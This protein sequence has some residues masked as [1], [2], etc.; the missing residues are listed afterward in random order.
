MSTRW[1]EAATVYVNGNPA[2][3]ARMYAQIGSQPDEAYARL[4][5][6]EELLAADRRGEAE[7]ELNQALDFYRRVGAVRMVREAEALL[8]PT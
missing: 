3:A 8:A 5:A 2:D 1:L 6:A 4:R 7:A